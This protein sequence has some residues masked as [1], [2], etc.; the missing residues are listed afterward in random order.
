MLTCLSLSICESVLAGQVI[1]CAADRP[2]ITE[3][4]QV[5]NQVFFSWGNDGGWDVFNV[6]YKTSGGGDKQV[7]NRSGHYHFNNVKRNRVYT[8]SVQGCKSRTFGSSTCSPWEQASVT[9][10]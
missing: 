9:T 6:R 8:I 2:C 7:E 1:A 5:G 3:A 4:R 10:H